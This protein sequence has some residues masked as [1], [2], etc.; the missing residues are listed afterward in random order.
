M[1]NKIHKYTH[2]YI[3]NTKEYTFTNIFD[4]RF[5]DDYYVIEKLY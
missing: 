2:I 5:E 3:L 4:S 1:Y